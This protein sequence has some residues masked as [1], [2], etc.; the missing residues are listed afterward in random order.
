MVWRN[1][2]LATASSVI[3]FLTVLVVSVLAANAQEAPRIT[4]E[5][6]R[7][8]L[9]NPD[10]VIIDVRLR[11][12]WENSDLKIKGAVR[13]DPRNVDSLISKYPKEKTLVFYCA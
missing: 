10:V 8:M 2:T 7:G 9:D 6:L 5:A 4:K 12:D 3:V 13:E 1:R 11:G